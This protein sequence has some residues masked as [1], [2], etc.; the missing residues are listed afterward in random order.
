MVSYWDAVPIGTWTTVD[1]EDCLEALKDE[2]SRA[3]FYPNLQRINVFGPSRKSLIIDLKTIKERMP[4]ED[5]EIFK[6]SLLNI[7]NVNTRTIQKH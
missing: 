1:T 3:S 7:I 6:R 2:E 4:E 5:F